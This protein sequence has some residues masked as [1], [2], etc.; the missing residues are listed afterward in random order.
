M[1][2]GS[3][4]LSEMTPW[5]IMPNAPAAACPASHG[6]AL[7]SCGFPSPFFVFFLAANEKQIIF[8]ARREYVQYIM[9]I[10]THDQTCP[11][12]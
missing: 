12:V 6:P 8:I 4:K 9:Q 10:Q 2:D 7:I 5:I 11:G 1:E 3:L